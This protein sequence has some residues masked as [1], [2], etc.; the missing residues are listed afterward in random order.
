MTIDEF[1]H[2]MATNSHE[3]VERYLSDIS[4]DLNQG[5]ANGGFCPLT[6]AVGRGDHELV[7]ILFAHGADPNYYGEHDAPALGSAIENAVDEWDLSVPHKGVLSLDM[8]KLLTEHGAD[9][10]RPWAKDGST[11]L[12]WAKHYSFDQAVSYFERLDW[13]RSVENGS[14]VDVE[15]LIWLRRVEEAQVMVEA[16]APDLNQPGSSG[17]TPLE[18]AIEIGDLDLIGFLV[19]HGA[20]PNHVGPSGMTPIGAAI[21][22]S[23]EHW[24]YVDHREGEPSTATLE[25][26]VRLG[27]DPA[28]PASRGTYYEQ[29][30]EPAMQFLAQ[31]DTN[32]QR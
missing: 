3:T 26:L 23:L 17:C 19:R 4:M 22:F 21:R 15:G 5:N 1:I 20:D 28:L 31:F 30:N 18:T 7:T 8:I 25:T 2:F 14:P 29:L 13:Q 11:P 24:D 16:E 6:W 10:H 32:E 9:P 12:D 27:A